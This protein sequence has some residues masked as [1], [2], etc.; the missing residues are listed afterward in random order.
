MNEMKEITIEIDKNKNKEKKNQSPIKINS[1]NRYDLNYWLLALKEK[2]YK[3][4]YKK[5]LKDITTLGLIDQYKTT[6]FGYKIII[7]FIQAKLK[8]IE[9]KYLNIT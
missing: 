9:N 1:S 5:V 2:M 6:E 8:I 3:R 7:I 4:A